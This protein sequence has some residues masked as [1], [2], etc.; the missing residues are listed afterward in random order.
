[1]ESLV[2]EGLSAVPQREIVITREQEIEASHVA[3]LPDIIYGDQAPPPEIAGGAMEG[4][5]V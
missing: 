3:L 5:S 2:E 1:V 4:R